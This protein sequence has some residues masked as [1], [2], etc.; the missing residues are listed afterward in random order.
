VLI[1][2]NSYTGDRSLPLWNSNVLI[3]TIESLFLSLGSVMLIK[4]YLE[5]SWDIHASQSV[6]SNLSQFLHVIPSLQEDLSLTSVS[7]SIPHSG[8][9]IC[10]VTGLLV[11]FAFFVSSENVV[12]QGILGS[13]CAA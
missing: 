8:S 3:R 11:D 13:F 4:S 6:V 9:I 2:F 5:V 1:L 7:R 10:S 12:S